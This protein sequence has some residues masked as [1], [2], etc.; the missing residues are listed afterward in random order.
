MSVWKK[1]E[2]K[3]EALVQKIAAE[4][5]IFCTLEMHQVLEHELHI[6]RKAVADNT[7][8]DQLDI[9]IAIED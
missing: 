1:I 5:K 3:H 7:L 4:N 2:K 9:K 8:D 6:V